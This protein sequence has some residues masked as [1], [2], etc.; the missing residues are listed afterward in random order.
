MNP[1]MRKLEFSDQSF[2][3]LALDGTVLSDR[4]FYDCEFGASAFTE[5]EWTG[6][7]FDACRFRGRGLMIA[8][9]LKDGTPGGARA[10]CE[11]LMQEGILCKETH[12][13]TIRFAP[14]LIITKGDVDWAMDRIRKVMAS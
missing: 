4:E 10:V 8:L 14:P 2:R 9:E 5:T 1:L 7:L 6:S 13:Y 12:T 3:G 11:A